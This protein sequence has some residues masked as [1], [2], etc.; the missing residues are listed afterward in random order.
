MDCQITYTPLSGIEIPPSVTL[1]ELVQQCRFGNQFPPVQSWGYRV[2][3][4]GP[5]QLSLAEFSRDMWW[6][7]E[8]ETVYHHLIRHQLEFA[9]IEDLL[10]AKLHAMHNE[11]MST[12]TVL[13]LG[14]PIVGDLN[15]LYQRI[16]RDNLVFDPYEGCSSK[17]C[18]V[19]VAE[20]QGTPTARS[21]HF[22]FPKQPAQ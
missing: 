8:I 14:S 21:P 5:R 4:R 19:L 20:F 10:A 13:C 15:P 11:T 22:P 12:G 6:E 18:R 17:R 16:Y 3:H 1:P 2:T 7:S 9:L